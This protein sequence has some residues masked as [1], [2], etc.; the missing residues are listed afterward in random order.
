[1]LIKAPIDG[2]IVSISKSLPTTYLKTN[3]IYVTQGEGLCTIATNNEFGVQIMLSAKDFS[4][5][6]EGASVFV[7]QK[8]KNNKMFHGVVNK[9]RPIPQSNQHREARF[10]VTVKILDRDNKFLPGAYAVCQIKVESKKQ[11]LTIPIDYIYLD[12]KNPFCYTF[13]NEQIQRVQVEIGINDGNFVEILN[14]LNI[15]QT[16]VK[17]KINLND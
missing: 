2:I 17:K 3:I 6:T 8:D 4:L 12:E 7:E 13:P 10:P 1:L 16:V 14:G 15:N 9:L 5:I 11:A